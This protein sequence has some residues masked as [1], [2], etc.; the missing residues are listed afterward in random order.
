MAGRRAQTEQVIYDDEDDAIDINNLNDEELEALAL[1]YAKQNE[2]DNEDEE[3]EHDQNEKKVDSDVDDV[4]FNNFKGIYFQDDPNKKYTDP[5][6]GAHF[7]YFDLC[8]RMAKLKELRKKIDKE[9]GIEV[10]ESPKAQL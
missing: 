5:E 10:I 7:E 9:L 6:T 2:N 1:A 8:K 3:E 4:D